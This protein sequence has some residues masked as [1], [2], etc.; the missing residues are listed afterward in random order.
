MNE[1]LSSKLLFKIFLKG[2]SSSIHIP[3]CGSLI[4]GVSQILPHV[5][6]RANT[7]HR[8]YFSHWTSSHIFFSLTLLEIELT[9]LD[10]GTF[11]LIY[12]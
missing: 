7:W 3:G 2:I 10:S 8:Y 11:L 9:D 1:Y 5:I 6:P 4:P 12:L